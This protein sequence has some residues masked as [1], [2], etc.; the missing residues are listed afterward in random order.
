MD[1]KATMTAT[2]DEII[3]KLID[4]EAAIMRENRLSPEALLFAKKGG[5]AGQGGRSP[6]REK[7][8]YK[9]D[10]DRKEKDYRMCFHCPG[11]GHTTENCLS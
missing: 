6:K 2:P 5:K 8:H 9:G 3:T 1:K 7:R 4:Q 11:R 10:N